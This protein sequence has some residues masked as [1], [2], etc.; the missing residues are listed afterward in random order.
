M[1]ETNLNE[2]M[3][4]DWICAPCG[5]R[6]QPNKK[7]IFKVSTYHNDECGWCGKEKA[8]TEPRDFGYPKFQKAPLQRLSE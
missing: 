3:Y 2:P 4:P 6:N 1:A 8:V 7:L 5:D